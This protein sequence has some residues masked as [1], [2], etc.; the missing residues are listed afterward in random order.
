MFHI[1]FVLSA[2]FLQECIATIPPF[3]FRNSSTDP[4]SFNLIHDMDNVM[5]G[6]SE[7]LFTVKLR[8]YTSRPADIL[9]V[10]LILFS[11]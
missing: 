7:L 8:P 9:D 1:Y 2:L 3:P 6:R 10:P 4:E 5:F 11:A